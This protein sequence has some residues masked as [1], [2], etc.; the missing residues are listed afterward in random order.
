[1]KTLLVPEEKMEIPPKFIGVWEQAI[2]PNPAWFRM[3]VTILMVVIMKTKKMN[4]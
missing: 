2:E 4:V 1:M 3:T